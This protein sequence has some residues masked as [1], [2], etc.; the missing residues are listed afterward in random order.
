MAHC[1]REQRKRAIAADVRTRPTRSS[2]RALTSGGRLFETLGDPPSET[3]PLAVEAPTPEDAGRRRGSSIPLSP[4]QVPPL[5]APF[6]S[7]R[8]SLPRVA[9]R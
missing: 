4:V 3:H 6:V 1:T 9:V 5:E 8:A 2:A 7:H